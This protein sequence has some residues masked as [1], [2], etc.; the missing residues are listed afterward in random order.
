MVV[1]AGSLA[2]ARVRQLEMKN[3]TP[4]KTVNKVSLSENFSS[5][6]TSKISS[7]L[8]GN[9]LQ[10]RNMLKLSDMDVII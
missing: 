2:Y 4:G 7:G 9:D 1:L 8:R 6:S 10:Y 3:N 5:N